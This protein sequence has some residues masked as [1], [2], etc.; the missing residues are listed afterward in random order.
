MYSVLGTILY[1]GYCTMLGD[2]ST[3]VSRAYEYV[4][5]ERNILYVYYTLIVEHVLLCTVNGEPNVV[6]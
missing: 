1:R 2:D 6:Y 4:K 5:R 3:C